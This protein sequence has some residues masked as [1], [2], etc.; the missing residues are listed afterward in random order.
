LV[1]KREYALALRSEVQEALAPIVFGAKF[2]NKPLLFETRQDATQ[3]T[4]VKT[5]LKAQ[6]GSSQVVTVSKLK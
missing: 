6:V 5:Q 3:V 1:E 4:R 2:V